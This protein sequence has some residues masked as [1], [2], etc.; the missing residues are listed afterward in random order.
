MKPK[1]DIKQR[2]QRHS[3]HDPT[4]G[5]WNWAK[6]KMKYGYGVIKVDGKSQLAHRISYLSFKG[7]L[8][9]LFVCH[10]CDNPSCVN[11]EH[12]FLGT[13]QDNIN[14]KVAKNRQSKV[15][16]AKGI[17]HSLAKLTEADVLA[18]RQS[19]ESQ[20]K[21]AVQYNTTQSNISLIKNKHSWSHI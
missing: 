2:I 9:Q 11:P 12:L 1:Q 20:K 4:T 21:L 3:V 5:C 19:T 18:I 8:D 6:Y 10:K 7:P 16:Q 14:D 13:N 15:G 17:L